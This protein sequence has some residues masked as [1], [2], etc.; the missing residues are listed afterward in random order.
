[1]KRGRFISFEGGEGSGKSTQVKLLAESLRAAGHEVI[2]TREP[3]G[4]EGAEAIRALLVTGDPTRWE[5]VTETLLFL[6]ARVQHVARVIQPALARGAYVISDRFHDSTRVYQG[7]GR[8]LSRHY[9]DMLHAA[10]LGNIVPDITFLLDISV[11]KGLKRAL[12]RGGNETRFEQLDVAFH[13]R[14][15]DGFLELAAHESER[16]VV[17]DADNSIDDIRMHIVS[18]L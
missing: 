2:V 13:Q 8:G 12:G 18:F 16:I 5:D 4:E 7:V 17:V 15:R 6:A 10:T 3:G 11:E 14:V 1:M 9:Y